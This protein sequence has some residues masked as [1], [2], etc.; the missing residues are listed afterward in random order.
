M[1]YEYNTVIKRGIVGNKAE[2]TK[3]KILMVAKSEFLEKGF[4]GAS[5][6][7]IADKANVTT[8]ALYGSFA[9]KED[10]FH[11]LVYVP[12]DTL[13]KMY[14]SSLNDFKNMSEEEQVSNIKT[15]GDRVLS[16]FI[17]Y[18]Y[19]HFDEFKL[20]ICASNGSAYANY[21]DKLIVLESRSMDYLVGVLRRQGYDVPVLRA[22]LSHM[23]V[24][25]Y[26]NGI[27]EVVAHDMKKEDAVDYI[28]IISKFFSSGW[29]NLFNLK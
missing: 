13:Y 24:S 14:D 3:Q 9:D 20:I 11:E 4:S 7:I 19:E 16:S 27:F 28:Q 12:A 21:V 17:D 23:L 25:A 1:I 18:I 15:F 26:F 5:L 10:I 2:Q 22:D 29:N 6:R 8:G